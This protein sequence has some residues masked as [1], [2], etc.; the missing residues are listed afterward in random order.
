[1]NKFLLAA[2]FLSIFLFSFQSPEPPQSDDFC[3][4]LKTMLSAAREGF[5]PIKG[6]ATTRMITG[7]EKKFYFANM[8]FVE[9]HSCYINDVKSY[10]ECECILE[11]DT[12]ITEQLSGHYES[13]KNK[14]KECLSDG[15]VI[16][17]QDSSNNYYLKGTKYKKLVAREDT[18]GKKVKFHLYIYSSMI[19]KKRVIELKFEG[20]GKK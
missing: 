19:E 15:W 9:D 13:Y 14:I 6:E 7:H 18:T 2:S 5:V 3:T 12:R 11:T 10:P 1:M 4:Q 20:I 17:E 16:M 8:K